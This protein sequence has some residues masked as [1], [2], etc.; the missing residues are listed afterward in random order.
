MDRN[1]QSFPLLDLS[2]AM[3]LTASTTLAG[4]ENFDA[5]KPGT[6]PEDWICGVTGKGSPIW[7]VEADATAP[8][9]PNLATA[10]F[11]GA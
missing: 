2:I 3:V 11:P 8:S 10:P 5:V 7:K 6:L 9:Q 4:G 1:H